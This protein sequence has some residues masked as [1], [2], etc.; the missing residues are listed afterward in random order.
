LNWLRGMAT[1]LINSPHSDRCIC[2]YVGCLE[3][4]P[5]KGY[6]WVVYFAE[7]GWVL[8]GSFRIFAGSAVVALGLS[9][10]AAFAD[11][12]PHA[13]SY[14]NSL[15]AGPQVEV[16][17]QAD[18]EGNDPLES[19]NR[20][21]FSFNEG[22]QDYFLRPVAKAYNSNV[23][24]TGRQAVKNVFDNLAS[25]VT[26]VND[27]LQFEF[28]RALVTFTR[29]F[30]NT[31]VGIGGMADVASEVGIQKHKEDFGQTLAV[32]GVGE[33]LYLVLPV[34]GPSNPRDAIGRF[35]VDSY[36]DPLGTYLD[37]I[38]ANEIN[39]ALDVVDGLLE[40]ADVVEELDQIKKTS[41]DYYAAI[42]SLYRQK[43]RAE[44]SNGK[45]L[46]LPP[47]P[48]LAPEFR[49]ELR[50]DGTVD[51]ALSSLKSAAQ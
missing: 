16:A 45:D 9:A 19:M 34:F 21:I 17:Q 39:V 28:E 33:G 1:S 12:Q 42:R 4:E 26:F 20:A 11:D 44:I 6:G 36:F 18:D 37:N 43:R 24:L 38:D 14:E 10:G 8:T 15:I 27:L 30:V 25:P 31:V 50:P 2:V 47:I 5:E 40:Y 29:T 23:P 48:D 49:G 35:L 3:A 51:S 22:V 46:D 41:V 13:L 7:R 32:W